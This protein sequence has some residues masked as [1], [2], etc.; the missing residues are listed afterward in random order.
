MIKEIT[1]D[2][3]QLAKNESF[4]VILQG[5][6]CHHSWN[7][8][9]AKQIKFQI[10]EAYAVD[11]D[12]PYGDKNKLGTIS[13]TKLHPFT[14][15][16]CYTQYHSGPNG[17][18]ADYDAIK[19]ALEVVKSTFSGKRIGMPRIG[20]GLAKGDWNLIKSIIQSVFNDPED[21]VTI[22]TWDQ[23]SDPNAKSSNTR[24]RNTSKLSPSIPSSQQLISSNMTN[25]H[26]LRGKRKCI[27]CHTRKPIKQLINYVPKVWCCQDKCHD[28][29]FNIVAS[30]NPAPVISTPAVT[31]VPAAKY[32][33]PLLNMR[34]KT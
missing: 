2:L 17:V 16:N 3:L 9:I 33:C 34:I 19:T 30:Y 22:V 7:G 25:P 32:L 27:L 6:N 21:D 28:K 20:A 29:F 23:V 24:H 14:V 11:V 8:G 31:L 13:Y 4:D 10:P 26:K 12:T 1:G 5:C 15:V 18:Y